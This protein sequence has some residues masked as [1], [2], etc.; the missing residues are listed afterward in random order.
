MQQQGQD[1]LSLSSTRPA[2]RHGALEA[3]DAEA[4]PPDL[5]HM[6]VRGCGWKRPTVL[7]ARWPLS[8]PSSS[9]KAL[10]SVFYSKEN[11]PSYCFT[12]TKPT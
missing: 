8:S 1:R 10:T 9:S 3:D 6:Y 11:L 7:A 12:P 4:L 2:L 5:F